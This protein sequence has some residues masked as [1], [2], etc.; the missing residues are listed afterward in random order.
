MTAYFIGSIKS[1]DDSWVTDY[2]G[3]VPALVRRHGG[4]MICRSTEFVRYEGEGHAPDYV[5]VV[6]FPS[7][8][9]IDAFMNDPDYAPYKNARIACT[10]SDIFAIS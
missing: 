4:E 9:A 3:A 2:V 5:V 6:K 1:H 8:A 10:I 7:M